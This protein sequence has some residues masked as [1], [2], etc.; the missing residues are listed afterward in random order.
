VIRA[1]TAGAALV[2]LGGAVLGGAAPAAAH[3]TGEAALYRAAVTSVTPRVAGLT[4]GIDHH[5]DWIEVTG[6]GVEVLGYLKEPYLRI[7]ADGVQENQVA[8]T[9]YLNRSF[10]QDVTAAGKGSATAAP[11]W[12][13]IK[14][15][16]TARWHDHRIH[17]MGVARPPAVAT[18]P[19]H[20][21]Q[22]GSWT[23]HLV[24]GGT[25]VTIAGTLRWTGEPAPAAPPVGWIAAGLL[26]AFAV[27]VAVLRIRRRPGG[28][29]EEGMPTVA[30]IGDDEPSVPQARPERP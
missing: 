22:L 30:V 15:G 14:A 8:P 16:K 18:D 29:A 7:T 23:V 28:V 12:K 9:T 6:T 4:V 20:A 13:T 2:V 25:P 11:V 19:E 24:A 10:F 21:H 17:W 1:L 26:A 27:V 3:G 5:G